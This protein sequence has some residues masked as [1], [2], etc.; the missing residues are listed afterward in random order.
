MDKC[1]KSLLP[2]E[3]LTVFNTPSLK[4]LGLDEIL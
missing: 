4:N 2:K 1:K 3:S